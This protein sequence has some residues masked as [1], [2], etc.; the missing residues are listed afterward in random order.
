MS[1]VRNALRVDAFRFATGL[2]M[3][4]VLILGRQGLGRLEE[5]KKGLL[6]VKALVV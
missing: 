2:S 3:S 6:T 5:N 1:K 4:S